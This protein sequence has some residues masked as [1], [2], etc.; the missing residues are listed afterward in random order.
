MAHVTASAS[1]PSLKTSSAAG[2]DKNNSSVILMMSSS[3]GFGS[4]TPIHPLHGSIIS[5]H[6]LN[7]IR[8]IEQ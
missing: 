8:N 2:N 1:T 4:G 3:F 7:K 5:I 6:Q